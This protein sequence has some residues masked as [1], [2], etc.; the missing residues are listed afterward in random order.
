MTYT[1][2]MT[3]SNDVALKWVR[4]EAERESADARVRLIFGAIFLQISPLLLWWL[5]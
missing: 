2:A 1:E 3:R 5:I 4:T